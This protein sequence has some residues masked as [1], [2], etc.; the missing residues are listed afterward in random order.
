MDLMT[1]PGASWDLR[2]VRSWQHPLIWIDGRRSFETGWPPGAVCEQCEAVP[3]NGQRGYVG[4]TPPES[5]DITYPRSDVRYVCI[6]CARGKFGLVL[7]ELTG[8]VCSQHCRDG[9]CVDATIQPRGV[10]GPL[11]TAERIARL[12]EDY[13]P[14]G[15][16][17]VGAEPDP[18]GPVTVSGESWAI[19][20]VPAKEG[21]WPR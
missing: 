1:H 15:W 10:L 7:D 13:A 19:G 20:I 12:K 18:R 16:R 4:P 21:I 3:E 6:S 11:T 5:G 14:R 9:L 8:H 2:T 17:V